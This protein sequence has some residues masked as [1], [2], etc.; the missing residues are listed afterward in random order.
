LTLAANHILLQFI[1]VTAYALDG[2]A[3]AMEAIVGQAIGAKSRTNLRRGIAISTLWAGVASVLLA[4]SFAL[5]G[6]QIVDLMTTAHDVRSE[7]RAYIGWMV[8][9]PLIGLAPWMLDGIFIGATRTRD[10]RNM[11]VLSAVIY[12]VC[13]CILIPKFGAH[14]LWAA[15]LISY[16]ARGFTLALRYPALE[17]ELT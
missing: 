12:G 6:G 1:E 15:L 2:F 7:A 4:L 10:M 14:G 17:R 11:M 16:C 8:F 5:F 3:F 13:A 9:V